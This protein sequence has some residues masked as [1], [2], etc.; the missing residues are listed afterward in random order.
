MNTFEK[1]KLINIT[2]S[3]KN[4]YFLLLLIING[5]PINLSNPHD[6][7]LN[8]I[9]IKYFVPCWPFDFIYK[10]RMNFR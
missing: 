5:S 2:I 7:N 9:V 3:C 10:M 6:L 4:T 8:E 1:G